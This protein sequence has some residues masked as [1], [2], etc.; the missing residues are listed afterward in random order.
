VSAEHA[1]R[2]SRQTRGELANR[3]KPANGPNSLFSFAF[4]VSV[5]WMNCTKQN[6]SVPSHQSVRGHGA[7]GQ[8]RTKSAKRPF[9][10]QRPSGFPEPDTPCCSRPRPCTWRTAAKAASASCGTRRCR[11]R[12]TYRKFTRRSHG[13]IKHRFSLSSQMGGT[14]RLIEEVHTSITRTN[15]TPIQS[16]LSNGR[17]SWFPQ[18]WHWSLGWSPAMSAGTSC[19]KTGFR[20][21]KGQT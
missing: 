3:G 17:Y 7:R 10:F 11:T 1:D 16:V 6:S 4:W 14:A 8:H 18:T 5:R 13:Q 21:T 9:C 19:K 20:N 2:D 12:G 15:R